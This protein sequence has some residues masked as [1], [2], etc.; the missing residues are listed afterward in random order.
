MVVP[1]SL[2]A[3]RVLPGHRALL[4]SRHG[5]A[6][7]RSARPAM[8]LSGG[9]RIHLA[10]SSS[11][12]R[13][14]SGFAS[15][16]S[17]VRDVV[18]TKSLAP[19]NPILQSLKELEHHDESQ[20][21]SQ[22]QSP[23][24]SKL[25]PFA[26]M[27]PYH[28]NGAAEQV[29]RQYHVDLAELEVKITG[30]DGSSPNSFDVLQEL[31]RMEAPILQVLEVGSLFSRLAS[32]PDD[33]HQWNKSLQT[34]RAQVTS[35]PQKESKIIY[36][37]LLKLPD[38]VHPSLLKAFQKCGV[39]LTN[40]D[41]RE[42]LRQIH[43]QLVL[44]SDRLLQVS[45]YLACPKALRLQAVSDMYNVIG[46][47]HQQAKLL[48]FPHVVAL[49]MDS[50][51][52]SLAQI[53]TMHQQVTAFL[54][55]RITQKVKTAAVVSAGAFLPQQDKEATPEE[56]ALW[57]GRR[58]VKKVLLLNGV[59]QG[60]MDLAGGLLGIKVEE[61]TT[62]TE[63]T[64]HKDVR[65]FHLYDNE[66]DDSS[67][68][69]LGSFYM[70]PYQRQDK[71]PQNKTR[72]F[73]RRTHQTAKPVAIMALNITPPSWDDNPSPLSWEETRS[74]LYEFGKALQLILT[75]TTVEQ[76]KAT[77]PVDVSEFLA[78]VS[79][80]FIMDK[81]GYPYM[82]VCMCSRDV[83]SS[84]IYSSWNFGFKTMAL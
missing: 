66:N 3:R 18:R 44:L 68:K 17:W 64:W 4:R 74:V 67:Q 61:D 73:T 57:E 59:I 48:G 79:I 8:M 70:D 9:E 63:S 35:L 50:H 10:A 75:Q 40:Q 5:G 54:E 78:N 1:N 32:Q 33:M 82:F 46:L 80:S 84:F 30:S 31:D 47:S 37:A 12:R 52:A 36:N 7:V 83:P 27:L 25:P 60:L 34:A 81:K 22:S 42:Q 41:E 58:S 56:K 26:R 65:L 15:V 14:L 39:H 53:E 69:Y 19:P 20:S 71:A 2:L 29:A 21:S 6:V 51:M 62:D 55:P 28:L 38:H 49:E 16:T 23:V 24:T 43:Y 13:P 11:S 77:I 72:L 76:G 45:D